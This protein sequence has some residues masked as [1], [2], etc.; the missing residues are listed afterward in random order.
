MDADKCGSN[1]NHIIGFKLI[2]TCRFV[3]FQFLL[4]MD[5]FPS[6][7]LKYFFSFSLF[8]RLNQCK[9]NFACCMRFDSIFSHNKFICI[10]K[11]N[12]FHHNRFKWNMKNVKLHVHER[13][14]DTQ[15]RA[16]DRK[17]H[18]FSISLSLCVLAV[19]NLSSLALRT[20]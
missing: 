5:R 1:A 16:A 8:G 14:F 4:S 12:A 15:T 19:N 3:S 6:F 11:T 13:K 18:G 7:H 10:N 2:Y 17:E 9:I 20:E